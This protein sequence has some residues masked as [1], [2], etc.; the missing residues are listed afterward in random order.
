MPKARK[1]PSNGEAI[2]RQATRGEDLVVASSDGNA[3]DTA[4]RRTTYA[5][6]DNAS[7]AEHWLIHGLAHAWSGGNAEGSFTHPHGPDA[8]EAMLDFFLG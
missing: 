5:T 4:F 6:L 1:D 7:R 2:I 8:S 3:A